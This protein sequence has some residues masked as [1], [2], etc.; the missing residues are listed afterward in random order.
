MLLSARQ[1]RRINAPRRL[2]KKVPVEGH[3]RSVYR[4][5]SRQTIKL[6]TMNR[7]AEAISSQFYRYGVSAEDQRVVDRLCE[8]LQ[9]VAADAPSAGSV[10]QQRRRERER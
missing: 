5:R 2:K 8:L 1:L 3:E 10:S 7:F 9:D 4:R 6:D